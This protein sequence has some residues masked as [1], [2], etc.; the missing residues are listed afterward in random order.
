MNWQKAPDIQKRVTA[1]IKKLKLDYISPERIFCFRGYG[2]KSRAQA[3]I[4]ALAKV[5]QKALNTPPSY[6]IEV[7]AEK[8]D[9]YPEQ[10]QTE[11]LVHELLHIPK[12][13]SGAL[14]P[15]RLRH[16]RLDHRKVKQYLKKL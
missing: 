3:R 4:W 15:H 6:V 16:F 13:F 8:F 2:S 10:K 1:L 11:I 5:W 9:R 12:T 7:I 14:R